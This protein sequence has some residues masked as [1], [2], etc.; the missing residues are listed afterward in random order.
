MGKLRIKWK[1][2]SISFVALLAWV[3]GSVTGINT[4][5]SQVKQYPKVVQVKGN[6]EALAVTASVPLQQSPFYDHKEWIEQIKLAAAAKRIAPIDAKL[7]RIWK[8]I[9]GYNGLEVDLTKTIQLAL[10]FTSIDKMNFIYKEI[11]PKINLEDL[12]A[13]P[14]YKGNPHKPMV[15][16]MINVAWGNEFIPTILKVLNKENVHATFFFDGSWLSQN[17]EVAKQIGKDGHELSNHAYSHKNMSQLSREAAIAEISKTQRLL[18]DRLGVHNTLFAPPSGDF[19]NQTVQIAHALHLKTVLWTLD[20]VD[21]T[22][23]QPAWIIRKVSSNLEPGAMI[24]MHPTASSSQ[25]LEG[26]IKEVKRR[27]LVLG[28]VS[29]LLSTNRVPNAESIPK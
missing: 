8:A 26:I 19:N 21:W 17:V 5:I 15:S 14:I 29:E 20:T 9:P 22:K 25:A 12:G 7:D 10:P 16:L 23:P 2:L 6:M 27:G 28:T 11:K 3:F 1:L 18:E 13:Q 4:Y 24:L